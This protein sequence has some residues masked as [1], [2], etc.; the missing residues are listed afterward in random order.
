MVR[1]EAVAAP[2]SLSLGLILSAGGFVAQVASVLISGPDSGTPLVWLPGGLL[3]AVLMSVA[4]ARWPSCVGGMMVG[5]AVAA[6]LPGGSIL[7]NAFPLIITLGAIPFGA[8]AMRILC[9]DVS[10]L[11]T[12][13]NLEIGR[14]HV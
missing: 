14:A 6:S 5:V 8:Y 10:P 3:L 13:R 1:L 11:R 2:S 7:A 9:N 12:F 4:Q